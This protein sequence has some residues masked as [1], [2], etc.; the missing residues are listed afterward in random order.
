MVTVMVMIM[1]TTGR[2]G[3][4]SLEFLEGEPVHPVCAGEDV[5]L[6]VG[7]QNFFFFLQY[8]ASVILLHSFSIIFFFFLFKFLSCII[9]FSQPINKNKKKV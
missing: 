4:I 3:T 5:F 9:Y 2:R 6:L 1:L 7:S 8:W